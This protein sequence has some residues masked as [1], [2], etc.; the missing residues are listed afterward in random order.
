MYCF[1]NLLQGNNF[2]DIEILDVQE[3]KGQNLYNL[4]TDPK[5][6]TSEIFVYLFAVIFS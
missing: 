4:K 2:L 1:C 5:I 3:D 6:I